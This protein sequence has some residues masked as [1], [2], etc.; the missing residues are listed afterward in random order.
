MKNANPIEEETCMRIL[1]DTTEVLANHRA[2]PQIAT[3]V[4]LA[5]IS[6]STQKLYNLTVKETNDLNLSIAAAIRDTT[7]NFIRELND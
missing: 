7:F 5:L 6:L 2:D 4:A 1:E 3:A